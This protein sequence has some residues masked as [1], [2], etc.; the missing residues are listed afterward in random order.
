MSDDKC[1]CGHH[2]ISHPYAMACRAELHQCPCEL[3]LPSGLPEPWSIA[4]LTAEL[5]R[6][7][8]KFPGNA[9][10][11]V[12]LME[13]VGELAQALLQGKP[14]DEIVKEALQVACVAVRIAE[15]GDSDFGSDKEWSKLK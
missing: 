14:K 13:E 1:R 12:A 3:Y 4:A 2:R 7:R 8:A 15:E 5:K 9:K 11:T 6:A 10:L